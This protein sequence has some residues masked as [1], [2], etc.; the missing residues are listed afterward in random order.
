MT[1]LLAL[2]AMIVFS[3]PAL[4]E[5]RPAQLVELTYAEITDLRQDIRQVEPRG[6]RRHLDRRVD[7]IEGLLQRATDAGAFVAQGPREARRP[8]P[9]R[10]PPP[11]PPSLS[12]DEALQMVRSAQFD[13]DRLDA[14]R[15]AVPVGAFTTDEARILADQLTFDGGKADALILLYP[16]VV[17]KHRFP[18]ALDTLTFRSNRERVMQT[19]G[20]G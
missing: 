10:P 18:M 17:D 6:L 8:G 11:P 5:R 3:S 2:S 7:R 14:L 4:S 9:Q 20:L 12:F 19:L 1:R 16:A 15:M 13:A